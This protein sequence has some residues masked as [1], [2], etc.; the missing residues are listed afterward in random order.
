MSEIRYFESAWYAYERRRNEMKGYAA[1]GGKWS[2]ASDA[3]G[4]AQQHLLYKRGPAESERHLL[5]VNTPSSRRQCSNGIFYIAAAKNTILPHLGVSGRVH[6]CNICSCVAPTY[7]YLNNIEIMSAARAS[8][9][10][11][12]ACLNF[13]KELYT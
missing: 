12:A 13:D 10:I 2:F 9:G 11:A 5:Q 1:S 3:A 4:Q 7:L 6:I 8:L